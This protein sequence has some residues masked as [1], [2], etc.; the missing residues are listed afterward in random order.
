MSGADSIENKFSYLMSLVYVFTLLFSMVSFYYTQVYYRTS[1]L[2]FVTINS[3]FSIILLTIKP[4]PVRTTAKG[5]PIAISS[6]SQ[7]STKSIVARITKPRA[8]N[9]YKI[10]DMTFQ[11]ISKIF[12]RDYATVHSSHELISEKYKSEPMF[13]IEIDE[14]IKDVTL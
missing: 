11:N 12:N 7:S 2:L 14:F 9:T 1:A 8:A 10:T 13:R 3:R 6:P 4:Q 5:T